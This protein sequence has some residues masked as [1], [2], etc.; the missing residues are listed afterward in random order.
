VIADV[1][2]FVVGLDRPARSLDA[3]MI[4]ALADPGVR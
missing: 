2:S 3:A 1:V 4:A